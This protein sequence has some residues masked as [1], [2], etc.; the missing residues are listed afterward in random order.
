M[1]WS[2]GRYLTVDHQPEPADEPGS[3]PF[4]LLTRRR[5]RHDWFV[6]A[7]V[8][9]GALAVGGLITRA[10]MQQRALYYNGQVFDDVEAEPARRA[11]DLFGPT[12]QTHL[13]ELNGV[14]WWECA[15][16]S[17]SPLAEDEAFV[18]S[19]R[20]VK[21]TRTDQPGPLVFGAQGM[22]ESGTLT[23]RFCAN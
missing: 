17:T 8:L 19:L 18:G 10:V 23:I 9:I 14:T 20:L 13:I 1:S 16:G 11:G 22:F 4:E 12:Y 21:A 5:R 15:E 7:A 2:V 6:A 3:D